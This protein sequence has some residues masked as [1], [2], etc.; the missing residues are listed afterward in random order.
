MHRRHAGPRA[1]SEPRPFCRLLQDLGAPLQC[2]ALPRVET[3]PAARSRA[4]ARRLLAGG[5]SGLELGPSVLQH[6]GRQV[7]HAVGQTALALGAR[8]ASLQRF[9]DPRRPV[10]DDETRKIPVV[11]S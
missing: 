1:I 10:G 6:L 5:R 4:T 3:T 11:N 8:E 2:G 9:D 7:A